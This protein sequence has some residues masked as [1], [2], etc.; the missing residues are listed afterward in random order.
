MGRKFYWLFYDNFLS[1]RFLDDFQPYEAGFQGE[2]CSS[3]KQITKRIAIKKAPCF[4]VP[5]I[6]SVR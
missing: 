4:K 1:V 5:F 2:Y 3:F 6:H